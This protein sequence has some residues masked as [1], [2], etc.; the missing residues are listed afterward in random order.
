MK[1]A[2]R[3]AV[4]GLALGVG[5]A[6]AFLV[7]RGKTSPWLAIVWLLALVA[8]A[9]A[10]RG[11]PGKAAPNGRRDLLALLLAAAASLPVLVR[12]AN[13]D[14]DRMHPDEFI[15]G[16][17]S[18]THD[19]A[20]SSF[21]GYM[22]EKWEWQGQFPKP[23]FFLQRVFFTLFGENTMTLRLSVQVYVV[24]VSVMLFLIVRELLDRRSAV[25]AV[26]LY[27]FLAV[28]VYLETLGFFFIGATAVFMVLFHFAL[29][30]YK[31]GRMFDAAM[32]G[33]ACGFCYL[34]YYS[35]YLAFPFLVVSFA[36]HWLRERRL[37]VVQNFLIALGGMFLVLVP[38]VGFVMQAGDYALR[39][40]NDMSLLH[41]ANSPFRDAVANG[42]NPIPIL[43][44]NM[45][46]ALRSFFRDGVGGGGGFDFGRMAYFE[47]FS[48][49]LLAAG[50]LAGLVLVFRKPELLLV[51]AAL[52][53]CL[54][55]VTLTAPPPT[56]HRFSLAFPSVVIL[57]TLPFYLLLRFSEI[58]ASVRYGL[59]GG[60]LLLF[61]CINER[62]YV[63]AVVRD[64]PSDELRLS[65]FVNQR[66]GPR[67]FYVAA[68]DS[69]AFQKIFYFLDRWKNR[70]VETGFHHHL[71]EKFNR[72]EKYVYVMILGSAFR[73]QF[74]KADPKGRY[75]R[76]S[77]GYSL[78]AN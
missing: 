47:G 49:A 56:C 58:P 34:M 54:A 62:R 32:A 78:F 51:F 6:V 53:G 52:A 71:L 39:R 23:Y 4:F 36:L 31:R 24:I 12:V 33:I 57:M 43:R 44:D 5:V 38:F 10:T 42:A 66:Y 22:P 75:F 63:E 21:F 60:L 77:I 3:A 41:G 28:S 73:E 29:R 1:P 16:Y 17:F 55:M 20:H 35:S 74:E 67:T 26:V 48:L 59:A 11:L 37:R 14:P 46:L 30:E 69:F 15:T 25:I 8:F 68:Y 2:A 61:V 18:A 9:T 19:F 40:A 64:Q 13:M 7:F 27:S 50:I 72:K 76:F 65:E 70:H 45:F